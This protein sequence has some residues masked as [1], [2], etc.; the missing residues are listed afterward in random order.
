MIA[1]ELI[2]YLESLFLFAIRLQMTRPL[3]VKLM[4]ASLRQFVWIQTTS[5]E[6]IFQRLGLQTVIYAIERTSSNSLKGTT[7]TMFLAYFL[8]IFTRSKYY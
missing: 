3:P 1:P 6:S 8:R 2:S 4:T 5:C 7:G